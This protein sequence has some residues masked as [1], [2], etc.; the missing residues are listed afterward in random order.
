VSETRSRVPLERDIYNGTLILKHDRT[1]YARGCGCDDCRAD[2]KTYRQ[3]QRAAKAR[4]REAARQARAA[5][6]AAAGLPPEE[7][8][9]NVT[10]RSYLSREGA[11]AL[12]RH[13][14]ETNESEGGFIRRLIY[15]AIGFSAARSD[16]RPPRGE[17]AARTA[18]AGWVEVTAALSREGK[19]ALTA[20]LA[21]IGQTEAGFI[22]GLV[23]DA[24]G[25]EDL[26]RRDGRSSPRPNRSRRSRQAGSETRGQQS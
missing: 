19:T 24:I 12:D 11:E 15:D 9:L 7:G 10:A 2:R 23:Y 6:R 25:F 8:P 1:G 17:R 14:E 3:E 16:G 5:A 22:R 21:R 26:A 13:L 20:H 18:G 4:E